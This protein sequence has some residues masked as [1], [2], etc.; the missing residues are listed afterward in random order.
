MK[1][2]IGWIGFGIVMALALSPRVGRAANGQILQMDLVPGKDRALLTISHS[3]NGKFRLFKSEKQSSVIVEAENLN[4]PPKLTKLVDAS[5][6]GG[7]VLQM[8]PYNSQ[9][10]GKPMAKLVLQLRSKA[11]VSSSDLPGKFVV[12]IKKQSWTAADAAAL[13]V[14]DEVRAQ[15]S[16]LEKS[17]D[18]AKKLVEVLSA[19]NDEKKYFGS[20]VSFFAKDAEVPDVFRLVGS[21]SELN[22][23]WDP[24]V[25]S[26]KT[27]LAIKDLPWDQL[28]DIVIQQKGYKAAV[29]GNVVRIMTLEAY[30]KQM[31]ARTKEISVSETLEPV[32]MAVIPL[33]FTEAANMKSLITELLQEKTTT[34]ETPG[35]AGAA[36]AAAA[37][38]KD[39]GF[40]RGKIEVDSRTNSLVV[41]NTRVS[42]ERIRRL[43]KELDI[44]V[45]QVLIDAKIIIASETFS[46]SVGIRWQEHIKSE[47]GNSGSAGVFGEGTEVLGG[48][49][50]AAD[51]ASTFSIANS[52]PGVGVIGFG[53][54]ASDRANI[55]AALELAEIN[56]YTKTVAAPRVMVINNKLATI[57]D[58]QTVTQLVAGGGNADAS[59]AVTSAKL[60]LQVTPQVTSHGSVQLKELSITKNAIENAGITTATTN[61]K[62]LK[63]DVLVDSGGTLVLGGIF[64]MTTSKGSSGIPLL[65]DLPFIGQLFR[66]NSESNQKD[67]LMVFITPQ[68][69]DPESTSQSL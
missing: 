25:E 11:D 48:G 1:T 37:S 27:S 13:R 47:S 38:V 32:I 41:T 63:T 53:F 54:G 66:V 46:K 24:E 61:E 7:P 22:I 4:I 62:G 19:P 15:Q 26:Q 2:G 59:K 39:Q 16:A 64:Q 30:T 51:A 45:P 29:M 21:A 34:T 33:S 23:I 58:G 68:I 28:L 44:A 17:E 67:E 20:R 3:G 42:V 6:G 18:V 49:S 60:S 36:A 9:H 14:R 57:S 5:A 40:K 12:V 8:T 65:K 56:G 43:V 35:A 69:I 10:G 50:T 31:E 52:T 55:K